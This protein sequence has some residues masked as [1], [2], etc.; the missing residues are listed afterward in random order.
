MILHTSSKSWAWR[1][2]RPGCTGPRSVGAGY[3]SDRAARNA[4][5]RHADS[6]PRER[7]DVD[8]AP[9]AVAV[10]RELIGVAA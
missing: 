7:V 1:C 10:S 8:Q 3:G 5:D 6:H 9:A 2:E 4:H